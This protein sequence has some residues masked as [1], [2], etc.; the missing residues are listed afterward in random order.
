MRHTSNVA[1]VTVHLGR[2]GRLGRHWG[3]EAG[4]QLPRARLTRY[5]GSLTPFVE[6]ETPHQPPPELSQSLRWGQPRQ[7]ASGV[8]RRLPGVWEEAAYLPT[9][10]PVPFLF[11][12]CP[13]A[14]TTSAIPNIHLSATLTQAGVGAPSSWGP[15]S[16]DRAQGHVWTESPRAP[17]PGPGL[18][19][20]GYRCTGLTSEPGPDTP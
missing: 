18:H 15:Q 9:R 10:W 1:G 4:S 20:P 3:R 19:V 17:T 2:K 8:E 12:T 6:G 11:H 7:G 16:L 13:Q 5:E 14:N